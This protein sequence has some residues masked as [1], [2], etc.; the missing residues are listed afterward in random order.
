MAEPEYRHFK[1]PQC[2]A[3]NRI[4]RTKSK[5]EA[6]CGR[7]GTSLSQATEA[8]RQTRSLLIR[9]ENCRTRNRIPGDKVG[10]PATCG[11]CG[12]TMSTEVLTVK[13]PVL[14][15]DQNFN[16]QVLQ[17]PLPV[18]LFCYATW[19]PSCQTQA[20]VMDDLARTWRGRVRIAK[21]NSDQSPQTAAALQVMSVPQTFVYDNGKQLQR[22]V[23]A[24][25]H[26]S[27]NTLMTRFLG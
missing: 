6:H 7:C 23:G 21:L 17:S 24:Q 12:A 11:Q 3:R 10:Q 19:C 15:N 9:C 8:Q 18:L 16:S 26:A 5:N 27:L 25:N 2:G 20:P 14:V 1:C 4:P 13:E 22:L